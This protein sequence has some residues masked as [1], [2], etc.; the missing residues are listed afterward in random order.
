M[1]GDLH[2]WPSRYLCSVIDDMRG[3]FKALDKSGPDKTE[4]IERIGKLLPIMLEEIQYC[5][6]IME[7]AVSSVNDWR[8]YREKRRELKKELR[9]LKLKK[10]RLETQIELKEEQKS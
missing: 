10:E 6:N 5:A 8:N 7:G 2:F 3:L 4:Q 1:S 9:L